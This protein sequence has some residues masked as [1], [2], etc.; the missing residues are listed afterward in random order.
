[1]KHPVYKIHNPNIKLYLLV[2]FTVQ[3]KYLIF[4][5]QIPITDPE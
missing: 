3:N 4:H 5:A 2:Q 1:M